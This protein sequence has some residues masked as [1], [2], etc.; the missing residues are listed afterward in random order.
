MQC[1][2]FC[3]E[4]CSKVYF[5]VCDK[6]DNIVSRLIKGRK[7]CLASALTDSADTYFVKF[8]DNASPAERALLMGAGL[9]I[10]YNYF[11]QK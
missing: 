2:C 11:E 4:A 8:P 5:D 1:D 10:D 7:G 3:G 6:D 9:F